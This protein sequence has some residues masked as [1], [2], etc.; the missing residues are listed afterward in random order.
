MPI[1]PTRPGGAGRLP[2]TCLPAQTPTWTGLGVTV[3]RA[4]G[5]T[6]QLCH[7]SLALAQDLMDMASLNCGYSSRGIIPIVALD[8]VCLAG[9]GKGLPGTGQADWRVTLQTPGWQWW[10][11]PA[12]LHMPCLPACLP[13]LPVFSL[14]LPPTPYRLLPHLKFACIHIPCCLPPC[15]CHC[16]YVYFLPLS[17]ML[18]LPAM[19]PLWG[20]EGRAGTGEHLPGWH[21]G[22]PTLTPVEAGSLPCLPARTGPRHCCGMPALPALWQAGL[23]RFRHTQW[24]VGTGPGGK[25]LTR[26]ATPPCPRH[27]TQAAG[28]TLPAMP[29]LPTL[30]RWFCPHL[31]MASIAQHL[32]RRSL[33][34]VM[35]PPT[36]IHSPCL[37]FSSLPTTMPSLLYHSPF[38]LTHLCSSIHILHSFPY[39]VDSC[40]AC[41]WSLCLPPHTHTLHADFTHSPSLPALSSFSYH[42]HFLYLHLDITFGTV[43]FPPHPTQQFIP[44]LERGGQGL[45]TDRAY[46]HPFPHPLTHP[47][48]GTGTDLLGTR[49]CLGGTCLPP[50][51]LGQDLDEWGWVGWGGDERSQN[52]GIAHPPDSFMADHSGSRLAGSAVP[53]VWGWGWGRLSSCLMPVM[54]CLPPFLLTLPWPSGNK[55]HGL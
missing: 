44:T 8:P 37:P 9:T 12:C 22:D 35:A 53:P 18:C 31:G 50:P 17:L 15:A 51:Y 13:V 21:W 36:S 2:P 54:A 34:W 11:M 16:L 14:C 23:N 30:P 49:I 38:S 39:I 6:P 10:G 1:I 7:P 42:T 19:C 28:G 32:P 5:A 48:Q 52:Q 41:V 29:A 24:R 43:A 4:A 47:P 3:P 55:I 20:R 27:A 45:V 25:C 33:E 26:R 40:I 46:R